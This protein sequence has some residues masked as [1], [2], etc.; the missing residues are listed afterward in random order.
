MKHCINCGFPKPRCFLCTDC[1]RP[2]LIS[3]AV[4]VLVETL[5]RWLL[6]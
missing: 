2:A 4:V 3:P 1:W 6:R 5:L